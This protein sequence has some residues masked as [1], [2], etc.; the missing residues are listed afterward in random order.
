M[1]L[2]HWILAA[3]LLVGAAGEALAQA[4]TVA[5]SGHV[6]D[7]AGSPIPRATV[8]VMGGPVLRTART[9]ERGAYQLTELLEGDYSL[10]ALKPGYTPVNRN[11]TVEDPPGAQDFVLAWGNALVGTV[12]AVVLNPSGL[13]IEGA[14][15]DLTVGEQLFNRLATDAAGS[16]IFVGLEPGAYGLR[17]VFGGYLPLARDRII[18]RAGRPTVVQFR[19]RRDPG[20]VG[21]LS[22]VVED[23][24]GLRIPGAVV[25]VVE[26]PT[27]RSARTNGLGEYSLARLAPD[28]SYVVECRHSRFDTRR[29]TPVAVTPGEPG[30]LDFRLIAREPGAGSIGGRVQ[31]E[32]G[33]PVDQARVEISAGPGQGTAVN[34]GSD[35]RY[36]LTGLA[37]GAGYS[38]RVT[39]LG[40][41]AIGRTGIQVRAG[42]STAADFVMRRAAVLAGSIGGTVQDADSGAPL[43]GVLVEILEGPS[44]GENAMT[45]VGGVYIL[46]EVDPAANYVLR[47]SLEG[48]LSTRRPLVIVAP[49]SRTT[50]DAQ[51]TP[52]GQDP[53]AITGRVTEFLG[54]A[55]AG[56]RVTLFEGPGAPRAVTTD[57]QGR[58]AFRNLPPGENYG[59]RASRRGFASEERTG[60][61]VPAG[62]TVPVAIELRRGANTGALGGQILDLLLRPVS[63]ATVRILAGPSA[64]APVPTG[65]DGRF[66]FSELAQGAY[67]IEIV[68]NGYR[69]QTRSGLN[70]TPER[71][72]EVTIVLIP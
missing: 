57:Q 43:G 4:E 55:L 36:A 66:L 19:L 69:A 28:P 34:T 37:T 62:A 12:E 6:R 53:G 15:V 56:V 5:L 46:P 63:D 2:V 9:D 51:L 7:A 32:T 71:T 68:S 49:G 60:I 18:V 41:V 30:R 50:V 58:F 64:P 45:G 48:Y 27:T 61:R 11:V 38:L 65:A 29:S 13:A 72:T 52:T 47:F 24:N 3:G 59:L 14:Q 39:A 23:L 44:A 1:R 35:G 8:R 42:Q 70:V 33:L 16:A 17:A 20:Q 10:Q 22:G 25:R 40:F 67:T 26:G 21:G 54:R 31:D